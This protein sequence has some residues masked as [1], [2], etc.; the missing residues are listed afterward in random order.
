M[1][2]TLKELASSAHASRTALLA[3]VRSS[4]DT[5]I[6]ETVLQKTMEKLECGW[7]EGPI[8]E[9]ELPDDA[10]VSCRFGIRQSS[11]DAVKIRL[12]DDSSASGVN[13]TVQ[14]ESATKLHTLDV[15]AALELLKVSSDQQWLGKTIDL[16]SAYRQL[17]ILPSSRWVSYVAVFDPKSKKPLIFAMLA[18]PFGASNSVY[19]FLR[20]AHSLWWLG[21]KALCRA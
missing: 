12:I 11:G 9:S 10:V 6:D 7:L 4:G 8:P 21:C 14:V 5:E 19:S 2:I 15:A 18:L 3:S 20:V 13:D 1:N 16:S 17:G